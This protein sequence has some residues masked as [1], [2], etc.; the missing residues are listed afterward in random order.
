LNS[1]TES[2]K[3]SY[4][5]SYYQKENLPGY[6]ANKSDHWGYYNNTYANLNYA[7][8]YGYRNPMAS[9]LKYGILTK[10]SYPTGGYTE[11]E[12]E[13]HDYRKQLNIERWN[14]CTTLSSNQLAGGLRIKRIK[15]SATSLGPS[16]VVKEYYYTSDY[17]QKGTNASVSSGVLGGQIQYYFTDYTVYAFNDKDSWR[18]MSVFSSISVLPACQNTN[19]SHIGY[20]EVIEKLPD[21]SF[22]RYQFTNFDNGYMD[23]APDAIIQQS[24][25]PY[26]YYASKTFER[27]A[28]ILQE[29]YNASG[30]KLKSRDIIYEKDASTNNYIRAMDAKYRNVCPGTGVSYDEGTSYKIYTYLLRPLNEI[31]K[32]FDPSSSLE[33]QSTT[34]NYTYTDKKLIR[35]IYFTNSDGNIKKTEYKYPF[36]FLGI[37]AYT[38]MT[39]N[40]IFSPIVEE[41]QYKNSAII[42]K[43]Y[44]DYNIYSNNVYFPKEF[45]T[46]VGSN[47]KDTRLEYPNQDVYGNPLFEV[48]NNSDKTVYLWSYN[49]QYLIAEIKNATYSD[50]CKA[51]GNGVEVTG[52]TS[53]E[54]IAAKVDPTATDLT[55]INNLRF[56][57]TYLKEALVTT[58]TYKPLVGI[59]TMTDPRGVKTTYEYDTFNRLKTI[60]DNKSQSIEGYDYHYK[61]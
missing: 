56:N 18:K 4:I 58:Y 45:S 31:E 51:I 23:E 61:N 30:K 24:H 7:D 19:E 27:G 57:T 47:L 21:N 42:Q 50:V 53:L 40:N 41:I 59:I 55:P 14:P 39:N 34:T 35:S 11:F 13:P 20:T 26:E 25:T 36:D 44:T 12:F 32:F 52:K 48:K 16:Q 8:Y 60:K 38:Q 10:I 6:M 29:D 37:T 9:V 28:L 54:T 49:Y 3:N 33:M 46:Q 1:L 22:T 5:F 15:N 43:D 17:L 2:G